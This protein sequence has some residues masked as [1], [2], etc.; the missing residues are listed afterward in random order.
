MDMDDVDN[1]RF[2]ARET[3]PEKRLPRSPERAKSKSRAACS[4]E[5]VIV[6]VHTDEER[7]FENTRDAQQ[8]R[9]GARGHN[10]TSASR[11]TIEAANVK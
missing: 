11:R 5:T 9:G 4:A 2:V 3:I 8:R 6:L 10:P 1:A 7:A